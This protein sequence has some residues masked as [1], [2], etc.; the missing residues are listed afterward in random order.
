VNVTDV[1][2]KIIAESTARGT[3]MAKLA[4]E[5]TADYLENLAALGNLNL[6]DPLPD[7]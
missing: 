2:D 4:T 5:M 3:T 1:D 6:R 7:A